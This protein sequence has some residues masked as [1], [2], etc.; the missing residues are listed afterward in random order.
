[1]HL[2]TDVGSDGLF[3]QKRVPVAFPR[4]KHAQS[5]FVVLP[6]PVPTILFLAGAR[7]P[8]LLLARAMLSVGTAEAGLERGLACVAAVDVGVAV[9]GCGGALE[10]GVDV[11]GEVDFGG[12]TAEYLPGDACHAVGEHILAGVAVLL[13]TAVVHVYFRSRAPRSR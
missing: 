6:R 8:H 5:L 3:Q 4:N 1:M 2:A 11:N 12:G 13:T 9:L 7:V 10:F